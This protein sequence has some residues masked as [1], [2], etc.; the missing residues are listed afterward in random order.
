MIKAL[1]FDMDGTLLDSA[2]K[3]TDLT[4]QALKECKANGIKVY[5]ATG[6]PPLLKMMLKLTSEEE[7]LISDGGVYYNGGC[8]V[9]GAHK[10][11]MPLHEEISRR[12]VGILNKTEDVNVA[13]QMMNEVQTLRHQLAD[14]EYPLWGIDKDAMPPYSDVGYDEVIKIFAYSLNSSLERIFD[15]ISDA[16]GSESNLYLTGR[17]RNIEIT[18]KNVTKKY[19][20][21]KIAELNGL[22]HN[23]IAVFGDD[24]NDLEMITGYENSFAMGNATDEIKIAAAHITLSNSDEGIYHALKNILKVI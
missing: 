19:G 6:R 14:A 11:Y 22:A 2:W 20:V 9:D 12:S 24:R 5:I 21:D 13:V 17:G 23:E 15:E 3:I 10:F 16:V 18:G 8:V 1:F 4:K 7:R